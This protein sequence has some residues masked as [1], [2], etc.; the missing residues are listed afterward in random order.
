MQRNDYS[1]FPPRDQWGAEEQ[2]LGFTLTLTSPSHVVFCTEHVDVS[3]SHKKLHPTFKTQSISHT[4][5]CEPISEEGKW[6]LAMRDNSGEKPFVYSH[7]FYVADSAESKMR[8]MDDVWRFE[9]YMVVDDEVKVVDHVGP[10]SAVDGV[11]FYGDNIIPSAIKQ[12]RA[13]EE[14]VMS[15]NPNTPTA[16]QSN[17]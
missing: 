14:T 4:T 13:N 10:D 7:V 17:R 5:S 11:L 15:S 12:S 8:H 1:V 16:E 2:T 3:V 9:E 6:T